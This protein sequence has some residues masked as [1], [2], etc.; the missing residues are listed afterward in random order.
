MIL[1]RL[2]WLIRHHFYA[3]AL[4]TAFLRS[5][6]DYTGNLMKCHRVLNE[7]NRLFTGRITDTIELLSGC[8][9][10]PLQCF[11]FSGMNVM[12]ITNE[13][14]VDLSQRRGHR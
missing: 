14:L 10:L 1:R 5:R 12:D 11:S 9:N 3:F 13:Y 4:T 6:F 7:V 8:H 2:L